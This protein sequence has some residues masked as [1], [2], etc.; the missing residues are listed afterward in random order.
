GRALKARVKIQERL[1]ARRI[2]AP[3]VDIKQPNIKLDTDKEIEET[4]ALKVNDYRMAFD[5]VLLE[6]VNFEIK[7]NDKVALVGTN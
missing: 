6:D 4:I 7:S 1:E 2:K 3:F 5:K